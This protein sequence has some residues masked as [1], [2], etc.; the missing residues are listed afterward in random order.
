MRPALLFALLLLTA[1][2]RPEVES[3]RVQPTPV[4]VAYSVSAAVPNGEAL[5]REYAAALRARLAT[6]IPV[7]PEG[8]AEPMHPVRVKVRIED[9]EIKARTNPTQVGVATGAAITALGVVTGDRNAM[10]HGFFWGLW[11][12]GNASAAARASR[13]EDRYLG[14]RPHQMTAEILVTQDGVSEPLCELRV[15]ASEVVDAMD[16]LRGRDRD[17]E[18]RIREEEAKAMARVV[19]A[20]LQDRFGW[21]AKPNPTFYH[22]EGTSPAPA[23]EA[24][25]PAEAMPP[26]PSTPP[27]PP[28][29]PMPDAPVAVAKGR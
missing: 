19:V 11:A 20:K 6:R 22:A 4:T 17:D 13:Q 12:G 1:C 21:T 24:T 23:P 10:F 7:V 14:Y 27:A 3:F 25:A 8:A 29:P 5:E 2:K 26:A 15:G 18:V 16:P 9:M 28:V